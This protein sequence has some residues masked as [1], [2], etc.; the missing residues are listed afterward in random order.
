MCFKIFLH[1]NRFWLTF[2]F[3]SHSNVTDCRFPE[4]KGFSHR[5]QFSWKRNSVKNLFSQCLRC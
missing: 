3:L 1:F 2:R 4:A 5:Q